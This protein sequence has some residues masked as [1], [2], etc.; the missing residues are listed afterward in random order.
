MPQMEM[1]STSSG[2]KPMSIFARRFQA[3]RWGIKPM[4]GF[5]LAMATLLA[6]GVLQ[7]RIIGILIQSESWVAHTH[8]VATELEGL[9]SGL[10]QAESGTRGYVATGVEEYVALYREGVGRADKHLRAVRTLTADDATQQQ[11]LARLV[12]LAAAKRKVM[13]NLVALRREQGFAAASEELRKGEGLRLMT[14]IQALTDA[15]EGR[16]NDLLIVRQA[17]SRSAARKAWL[18]ILLGTILALSFT[19]GASWTAHRDASKRGRAEELVRKASLYSR[20]LLE[21]SLDPLVTISREGKITDVNQATELATG[22][23]RQQLIGSDFSTYFTEPEEA[24]KGYQQVF[25]QG[26]VQDYPLAIR[27]TSGRVTDVLYNATLFKNESG[28]V[29]GVFAAARDITKTKRAEDELRKSEQRFRLAV[30]GVKD[31]AIIMLDPEGRVASW[32]RGAE[33]LKGYRSEEIV[34]QHFSCFYTREDIDRGKPQKELGRAAAQGR[35]EDEGWRVRKDHSKFWANVV[36]T[37]IYS[38]EGRPSGFSKVTC[39]ITERKRA[40]EELACRAEELTRSNAELQQ[41]AY[42]ASHDLQEPLRMVASF[43]QLLAQR[44]QGKL[45]ADADEFIGYAVGGAR[46]MQV[47]VNDL[48]EYSRVGTRGKEF[49]PVDCEKL[50][51]TVL[52]SLQKTL[53]ESDGQVTHDPLP[54]VLGDETQ[55]GQVLLNLVGNALKFHGSE[56]PRVHVS[57]QEVNG[58]WRFSVRD[59]GIGI[60]PQQAE[61]IFLLFQRLHTRAE[62]P[63]TGMGLAIAKKIVERHGGRIWVESAPGKG[64]TFY[65]S[66]PMK[67]VTHGSELRASAAG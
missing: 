2:E 62:Y 46:R 52:V 59:N 35:F 65:F 23:A 13:E 3:P 18:A 39:D 57:A 38:N 8:E 30:E 19:L 16:E 45:G 24:R 58:E 4:V 6:A 36:I 31:Y 11:N 9:Y 51:E 61:R 33:L 12:E 22:V 34:G 15:M 48:L 27:H 66:L 28:H 7:Y 42:V 26:S 14:S 41:F 49:S 25:A 60:D 44:Y 67:E 63:G 47:L 40:E 37:P 10:Q 29:E 56:P 17:A 20:N 53:E 54:A 50:L 55:L 64:S 5:G 32:N 1:Q 21:A 43:T